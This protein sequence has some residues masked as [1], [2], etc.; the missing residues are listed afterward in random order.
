MVDPTIATKVIMGYFKNSRNHSKIIVDSH[1]LVHGC[2]DSRVPTETV[3]AHPGVLAYATRA[4]ANLVPKLDINIPLEDQPIELAAAFE[5]AVKHKGV[6]RMIVLGHTDCGG[7]A[8]RLMPNPSLPFVNSWM[9]YV[10]LSGS[11]SERDAAY[12][13]SLDKGS[14]ILSGTLRAAERDC[15]RTSIR[16][17]KSMPFIKDAIDNR[18]LSLAGLMCNIH[19]AKLEIGDGNRSAI[20]ALSDLL[21]RFKRFRDQAW[22]PDGRMHDLVENGQ[23]PKAFILT[24]IS[25]YVDPERIFGIEPGDALVHR[26]LGGHYHHERTPGG[27]A[28]AIEFAIVAK[29]I[30]TFLNIH[31]RNDVNLDYAEGLMDPYALVMAFM[32]KSTPELR[33]WRESRMHPSRMHENSLRATHFGE[34][35]HPA[36]KEA[37]RDKKLSVLSLL[38]DHEKGTMEYYDPQMDQLMLV[39]PPAL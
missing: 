36:V 27:L 32:E 23:H 14:Y 30:D 5:Y 13:S 3:L 8:A 6:N 21:E 24:G 10:N 28:A 39:T 1:E 29:K 34:M 33:E 16:N 37:I 11:H 35:K 19:E 38:V 15:L 17:I 9:Q 2:I 20:E 7:A 31:H 25:P 12:L 22:G 18:G 26:R 4:V